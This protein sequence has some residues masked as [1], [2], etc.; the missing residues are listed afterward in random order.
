MHIEDISR[1]FCVLMEADRSLVH[2]EAFNVGSTAENYR[3]SEVA[4]IVGGVTGVEVKMSDESFNDLRNYRVNCDKL[5]DR[6]PDAAPRWTVHR[7]AES[8]KAAM[9]ANGLTIDDLEGAKFMR[10]RHLQESV[11]AGNLSHD[12]RWLGTDQV[13][14]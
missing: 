7:G 11:A 4:E 14:S 5:V 9:E 10:L 12:L 6:F 2:D 3:I 8:L 13:V 1:A